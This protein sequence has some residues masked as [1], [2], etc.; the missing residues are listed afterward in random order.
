MPGNELIVVA[1]KDHIVF[2]N[3]ELEQVSK[4]LHQ[5]E[6]V[7]GL[8]ASPNGQMVAMVGDNKVLI[9]DALTFESINFPFEVLMARNCAFSR[10]NKYLGVST[11]TVLGVYEVIPTPGGFVF[12]TRSYTPE[13]VAYG[14]ISSFDFNPHNSDIVAIG[15]SNMSPK[16]YDFS[17]DYLG[18]QT[19]FL[20]G[21]QPGYYNNYKIVEFMPDG[22]RVASSDYIE[23]VGLW[24]GEPTDSLVYR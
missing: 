9:W 13:E 3:I 6:N 18:F 22:K 20:D 21:E 11:T 16:I 14:L 17:Q 12:E 24:P 1:T 19:L 5:Q 2:Y 15:F 23:G 8:T 4:I 10:D 7:Y